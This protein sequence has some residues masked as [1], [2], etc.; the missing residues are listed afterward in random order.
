LLGDLSAA[1]IGWVGEVLDEFSIRQHSANFT[2][3][4]IDLKNVA[5]FIFYTFFFIFLTLRVLE[6]RRWRLQ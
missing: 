3:G 1:E 5:Y 6:A 4:V 2:Q